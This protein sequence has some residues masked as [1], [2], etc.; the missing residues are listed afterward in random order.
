[1]AATNT[2]RVDS[3]LPPTLAHLA[4]A[5]LARTMDHNAE[6]D[7]AAMH[8][9]IDNVATA[10]VGA[11]GK[12]SPPPVRVILRAKRPLP[13]DLASLKWCTGANY[14]YL[15]EGMEAKEDLEF[16]CI[17]R[18]ERHMA[19]GAALD[20]PLLVLDIGVIKPDTPP[21]INVETGPGIHRRVTRMV[22]S[23]PHAAAKHVTNYVAHLQKIIQTYQE[24]KDNVQ[25]SQTPNAFHQR[26]NAHAKD[27]APYVIYPSKEHVFRP[28][29]DYASI[30]VQFMGM[31][32]S[33][34]LYNMSKHP[35]VDDICQALTDSIDL[36]WHTV[37]C[38]FAEEDT[39]TQ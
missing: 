37:Y 26:D 4:A 12:T 15:D 13:P 18:L 2:H 23:S 29:Y 5:S 31:S 6:T 19:T 32:L 1:M 34:P 36:L 3:S 21:G 22:V 10:V 17:T 30:D 28:G 35:D 9:I 27:D 38:K 7:T 25:K 16:C 11:S 20:H 8:D 24:Q 33:T 39:S 14:L